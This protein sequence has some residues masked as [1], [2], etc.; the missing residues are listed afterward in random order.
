MNDNGL[1]LVPDMSE[2]DRLDGRALRLFL[3]VLEEGSVTAAAARL[4]VTQS[5]VSHALKRLRTIVGDPLFVRNGKGIAPTRRAEALA[6]DVRTI[7]GSMQALASQRRFHPSSVVAEFAIA[8]DPFATEI[9]LPSV[10]RRLRADAPG[11]TIRITEM[12]HPAAAMP[13]RGHADLQI[14]PAMPPA[15]ELARQRLFTDDW[16]CYFDAA[17]SPP[18]Q[19]ARAFA[20]RRHAHVAP[21]PHGLDPLTQALQR[22]TRRIALEVPTLAGLATLLRGTDLVTL[23]P[24]LLGTSLM[25]DFAYC[26]PPFQVP[27]LAFDMLWHPRDQDAPPCMSGSAH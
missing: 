18:P 23:L 7:L 11:V 9:L 15:V 24:S 6:A 17:S 20:A 2:I 27:S 4:N 12:A 16:V 19:T 26:P 3:L 22:Q 8:A 21:H 10:V 1:K 14:T 13:R 25:R 5:A